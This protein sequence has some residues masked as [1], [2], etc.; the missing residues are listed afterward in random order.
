MANKESKEALHGRK[1]A[2]FVEKPEV[3]KGQ[4]RPLKRRQTRFET[5]MN[6]DI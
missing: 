1:Q 4:K 2:R 6:G 3:G 5:K